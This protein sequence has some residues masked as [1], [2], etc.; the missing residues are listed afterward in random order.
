M[1]EYRDNLLNKKNSYTH[2]AH[3]YFER[4][5]KL[6]KVIRSK[7][8]DCEGNYLIVPN[9]DGYFVVLIRSIFFYQ[10]NTLIKY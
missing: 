5:T 7:W 1:P 2:F 8:K 10:Q 6:S 4:Y 9:F 3:I